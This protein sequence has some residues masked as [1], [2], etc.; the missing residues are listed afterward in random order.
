MRLEATKSAQFVIFGA[1]GDLA[2]RKLLPALCRLADAGQLHP[3]TIIVGVA[4]HTLS[5]REYRSVARDALGKA[6]LAAE[7]ITRFV[8][9]RLRYQPIRQGGPD[10]FRALGQRL[11]TLGSGDTPAHNRV[12]Y[13]SL[14]PRAFAATAAGLG[15]AGLHRSEGWTRL[16]VEKPFGRDLA[17]AKELNAL[18]HRH[19]DEEQIYRIDHYLGKDT[20][21]NLLVFRFANVLIESAWNRDRIDS[22]QI[23]VAESLGVS[24]RAGY[25]DHAGALRDMV[26][27]HLTQLLTLVA[28]EVPSTFNADAIRQ[29]KIKVLRSIPP[30]RC[31]DVVRGQYAAGHLNGERAVGYLEEE[32]VAPGSGTETFVAMKLGIDNWRWNG[33]P[34]FLRSGKRLPRKTTQI[35]VRF[36]DVP[37]SLFRSVDCAMDTTDV[38]TIILQPHEGFA[39]YFDIKVPGERFELRRI[40]LD[41]NYG[42]MFDEMPE[43]Y[44]T[45][46]LDVLDGDQTLFV[47]AAEV[48]ESWRVYTP[49]IESPPGV[50]PYAAGT[51]GPDAANALAIPES[52]LLQSR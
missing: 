51:W 45:L 16:V 37:V 28:M 44:Q 13:L 3:D 49:L 20:V 7:K 10:D 12:F 21:Q 18:V 17:S 22:V 40:P 36:R 31:E 23:A 29:E 9:D 48:E 5:D 38:L 34:F 27:N 24:M 43:A 42:E 50:Q 19:F 8:E 4:P 25:Y 32:G 33:V 11:G 39:L 41:F 47:H 30:I 46:L 52:D 26:Q 35:T 1:T 14:P 6:G 2:R 15:E